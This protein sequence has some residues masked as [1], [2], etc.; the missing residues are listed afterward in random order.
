M[1]FKEIANRCFG[2]DREF[3]LVAKKAL[4]SPKARVVYNG[5]TWIIQDGKTSRVKTSVL[6]RFFH[7]LKMA[8]SPCYRRKFARTVSILGT[9]QQ[10]YHLIINK[11]Q[12]TRNDAINE[13]SKAEA[14]LNST[15]SKL[16]KTKSETE[17]ALLQNRKRLEEED[18][19]QLN[20]CERKGLILPDVALAKIENDKAVLRM[21][22]SDE[23]LK[24]RGELE[25][26]LSTQKQE[27][28][29]LILSINTKKGK[30][31]GL[32]K[33]IEELNGKMGKSKAERWAAR[34][35]PS[36]PTKKQHVKQQ[37]L[38]VAEIA[39]VEDDLV[40]LREQMVPKAEQIA[41]TETELKR[42]T[43]LLPSE[44]RTISTAD[45]LETFASKIKGV[46]KQKQ[47]L[48][49]DKEFTYQVAEIEKIKKEREALLIQYETNTVELK[50]NEELLAKKTATQK[51]MVEKGAKKP[52]EVLSFWIKQL[53]ITSQVEAAQEYVKNALTGEH[54][55]F[56]N[57]KER[58]VACEAARQK[59]AL[60]L[61]R[62]PKQKVKL[63]LT[64]AVNANFF[65]KLL[66]PHLKARELLQCF[67]RKQ[68]EWTV[69]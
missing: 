64:Q 62:F 50:K 13:Q 47:D 25:T 6:D 58:S 49:Q 8:F 2:K 42:Y 63:N 55:P 39:L 53:F 35:L 22:I 41:K 68:N 14:E 30:V 3:T 36:S 46:E 48:Q 40:K 1:Q 21:N 12:K 59:V 37:R 54:S 33:D 56:T 9:A 61:H 23:N 15:I 38:A 57:D 28:D 20:Y 44:Y 29:E 43:D 65:V 69:I 51:E 31:Q 19:A 34:Q 66:K 52:L 5:K 27:L 7:L 16:K 17:Q 18:A 45:I 26:T 24:K 4:K 11:H 32:K 10:K 67:D 60:L